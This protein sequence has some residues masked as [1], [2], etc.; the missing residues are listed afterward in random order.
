MPGSDA[1]VEAR[2]VENA[3]R[4]GHLY[5]M[6]P[7]LDAAALAPETWLGPRF[8][9]AAAIVARA[10]HE[11]FERHYGAVAR[12]ALRAGWPHLNADARSSA[13]RAAHAIDGGATDG[14][15]TTTSSAKQLASAGRQ[16]RGRW[17]DPAPKGRG[18]F[19]P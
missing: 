9:A 17:A 7:E 13:K 6:P 1:E 4:Y 18:S 10:A 19:R 3:G 8:A 16:C 2:S 12:F 11:H 14:K 15:S 5:V